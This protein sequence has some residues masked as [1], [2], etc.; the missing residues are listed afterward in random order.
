VGCKVDAGKE[1]IAFRGFGAGLGVIA[2]ISGEPCSSEKKTQIKVF[3]CLLN[4]FLSK[5]IG[6]KSISF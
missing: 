2:D 4:F 1:K 3:L 5:K 6:L